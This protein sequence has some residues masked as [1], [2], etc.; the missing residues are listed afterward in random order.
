MSFNLTKYFRN[1]YL[2]EVEIP[3]NTWKPLSSNELKDL[4]DDILNLIQNA[5]GPI[6]GHPNYKSISDIAG[7]DYQVIDLDDDPEIDA[8]TVSKNRAGGTKHVG[9]GHDGTKP[10]KRGSIGHTIN[11]LGKSSNYIEASGKMSDILQNANVSQVKDGETIK[12]ALKGKDIKLFPDGSYE[13]KLGGKV[14]VKKMF[15]K[16]MV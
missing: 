3:K 10:A 9:L 14:F 12:K 15:G 6:G 8:V 11:Q 16:P 2:N 4:E 5:Y 13:R 1:K 7:S